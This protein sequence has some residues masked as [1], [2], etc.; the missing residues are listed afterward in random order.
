MKSKSKRD[1]SLDNI[2]L[3]RLSPPLRQNQHIQDHPNSADLALT[4]PMET[5]NVRTRNEDVHHFSFQLAILTRAT[6]PVVRQNRR[7]SNLE[8]IFITMSLQN[9]VL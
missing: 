3:P 5:Q 4:A 8:L 7:N 6:A 2:L 1:K 9:H